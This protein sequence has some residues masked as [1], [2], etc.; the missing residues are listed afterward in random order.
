MWNLPYAEVAWRLLFVSLRIWNNERIAA[1][2]HSACLGQ[3]LEQAQVLGCNLN[4]CPALQSL[5]EPRSRKGARRVGAKGQ[6]EAGSWFSR[7]SREAESE[8][9]P[10]GKISKRTA[11]VLLYLFILHIMVRFKQ[12]MLQ[13]KARTSTLEGAY[14]DASSVTLHNG[15]TTT[16]LSLSIA[17]SDIST[18]LGRWFMSMP[19]ATIII[20]R[21]PSKI[22]VLYFAG[23]G[24][25]YKSSISGTMYRCGSCTRESTAWLAKSAKI[26]CSYC[27]VHTHCGSLLGA[28]SPRL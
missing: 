16:P 5:S 12:C 15:Y 1:C 17:K 7:W 21:G 24:V 14:W 11:V 8:A 28:A 27:P 18:L 2:S 26:W 25:V 6:A 10:R 13:S 19:P 22:R 20:A 23:D 9:G 4:S 3:I